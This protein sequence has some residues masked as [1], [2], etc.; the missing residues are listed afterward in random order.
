MCSTSKAVL[1]RCGHEIPGFGVPE[2]EHRVPGVSHLN[3]S[4]VTKRAT[5]QKGQQV[6]GLVPANTGRSA[7][8]HVVQQLIP[9]PDS[10]VFPTS[11]MGIQRVEE[12]SFGVSRN[13][14]YI[15][16]KKLAGKSR[17]NGLLNLWTCSYVHTSLV[18]YPNTLLP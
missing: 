18:C 7:T 8:L 12:K 5:H 15:F 3:F 9:K 4:S 2:H 13:L 14:L 16:G 6:S 11:R 10:L 17:G 1:R